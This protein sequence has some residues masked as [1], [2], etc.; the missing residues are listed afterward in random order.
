M[1][2]SAAL[3]CFVLVSAA[4]CPGAPRMTAPLRGA[5]PSVLFVGNSLT[6]TNDLP[7]M[8]EAIARLGVGA[9]VAT[10]S[11]AYPNYSLED[12]WYEG[13]AVQALQGHRWAFVVMQ[14]GP[15]SLPENQA[16][17]A[18][19]SGRF[20]PLIRAAGAEPVLFMVWPSRQRFTDFP[21]VRDSYRNAAAQLGGLFAPAGD[22]WLAAWDDDP[23]LALYGPDGFHPSVAGTYLA[24]LVLLGRIRGLDPLTLP[25]WIPYGDGAANYPES[26]VV[27][28]QTAAKA[29]L[30]RNP[31]YPVP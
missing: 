26:T 14:Q 6:Y 2:R 30:E 18:E 31:E 28:I 15:S 11:V 23:T 7:G 21:A 10:A 1:L 17:L 4:G 22:G 5:D 3:A 9:P 12:H 24:A 19:W 13:T 25:S 8:L 16:H 27:R 29:A 20:A